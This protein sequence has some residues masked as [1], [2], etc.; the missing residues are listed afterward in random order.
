MTASYVTEHFSER[1]VGVKFCNAF[2]LGAY[3]FM[4]KV[5]FSIGD[6][7]IFRCK[8]MNF[9]IQ[10]STGSDLRTTINQI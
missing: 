3:K 1:A 4:V 5:S 9:V 6:F 2:S 10:E 8:Y 7:Y